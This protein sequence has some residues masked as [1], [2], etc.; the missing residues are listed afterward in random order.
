MGVVKST[1]Q[2]QLTPFKI[3]RT[4]IVDSHQSIVLY[5][6]GKK[7][8]VKHAEKDD[9]K[10]LKNSSNWIFDDG[11]DELQISPASIYTLMMQLGLD[12]CKTLKDDHFAKLK[13]NEKF[14][15]RLYEAI[16]GKMMTSE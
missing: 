14:L 16:Y 9:G 2:E 15:P 4:T 7:V 1:P 13:G 11:V 12:F 8:F 3:G 10:E 6:N 5:K